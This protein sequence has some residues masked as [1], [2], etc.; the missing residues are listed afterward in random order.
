MQYRLTPQEEERILAFKRDMHM[1]PELA[2]QEFRTTAKIKE[3]LR[4][5][6]SCRILPLPV[7]TGV[8]ARIEGNREGKEVMLRADIDALPV[9]EAYESPWKSQVPGVMHACGHDFHTASLLGAA[10]LLSKAQAENDLYG[11]IDLLFQPAEEGTTGAETMINAGLF[12][13]I[14]PD[15]CFGLHNWP[16]VESGTIVCHEGALMAAK[17]SFEIRIYGSGGHGSMPHLN[18]DPIVCAASIVLSLQTVVSRNMNPMDAAVL[19]IS[20]IEGGSPVNRVADQVQMMGTVRSLSET[21]LDRAIARI[22]TIV[23]DTARAYE[24]EREILWNKR[25][26]AVYN[27]PE[28]TELAHRCASMTDCRVS[29][30][31]AS[32]ASEDFALYR[33]YVPSFFYWVGSTAPQE[34]KAEDLHRPLFHTDDSMLAK[35]AQL[36]AVSADC[37]SRLSQAEF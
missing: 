4:T 23:N 30:A 35:A 8:V 6:P 15:Y 32:L 25:I 26:P 31:L 33:S 36:L 1:H 11:C 29:D 10:M 20:L 9:K 12:E 17:R 14:H 5:L 7:D 28:M 2:H 18:T 24:C 16:S 19:S 13:M 37:A 21:A 27:S 22:E 3:F 34:T